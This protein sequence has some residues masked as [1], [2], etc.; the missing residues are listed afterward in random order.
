MKWVERVG[1]PEEECPFIKFS[2]TLRMNLH[3]MASYFCL[4]GAAKIIFWDYVKA[5]T[6]SKIG[7]RNTSSKKSAILEIFLLFPAYTFSVKKQEF[8]DEKMTKSVKSQKVGTFGI[9]VGPKKATKRA[10]IQGML[11]IYFKII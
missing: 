2:Y 7:D 4:I 10:Y 3:I 1:I 5:K 9:P 8:Y 6:I 11:P